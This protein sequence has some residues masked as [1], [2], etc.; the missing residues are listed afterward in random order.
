M[1]ITEKKHLIVLTGPT[2]VTKTDLSIEIARHFSTPII[3]ADSRQIYQEMRIGTA[4]PDKEQLAQVPHYF[5]GNKSI[6]EYYN[7]SLYESE[8]ISLLSKIFA[9]KDFAMLTGGSGM[10][11]D[12]VCKGIDDIPDADLALRKELINKYENEGLEGMRKDL[13]FLDPQ[14]YAEVDLKN[15]NR[16]LRAIEVSLQTGKPYSSFRRKKPKKRDFNIIKAGLERDRQELYNRINRR[17]DIMLREGLVEA[18]GKLFPH[19]ELT[20]LKTVGYRELFDHFEGK[21]SLEKAIELIKRNTRHYAKRQMTWFKR[22]KE[23]VWFHPD[24]SGRLI[25]YV[26]K[27][28]GPD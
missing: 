26:S 28:A 18:A 22:D 10:Y 4:M 12:A 23:I 24:E 13:K 27:K 5:I 21:H 16:M 6:F 11:I 9:N 15:R 1:E 19:R 17:V 3:S 2:A 20:A 25:E 14:Y 7:A 8:V